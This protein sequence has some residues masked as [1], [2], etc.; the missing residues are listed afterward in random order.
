MQKIHILTLRRQLL[1][2]LSSCRVETHRA[3]KAEGRRERRDVIPPWSEGNWVY[4]GQDRILYAFCIS[5]RLFCWG[6]LPASQVGLWEEA[7]LV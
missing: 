5:E 3:F 7:A 2:R 4:L 6:R 1:H